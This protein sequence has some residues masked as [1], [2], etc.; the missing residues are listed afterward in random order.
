MQQ[1]LVFR[2]RPYSFRKI[3]IS[4]S[5]QEYSCVTIEQSRTD[6]VRV[7]FPRDTK[8]KVNE[9][10][11]VRVN[12]KSDLCDCLAASNPDIIDMSGGNVDFEGTK[13]FI[14]FLLSTKRVSFRNVSAFFC[15]KNI[16]KFLTLSKELVSLRVINCP[17]ISKVFSCLYKNSLTTLYLTDLAFPSVNEQNKLF[18][19]LSVCQSLENLT[20]KGGLKQ[21]YLCGNSSSVQDLNIVNYGY[22]LD[23][24]PKITLQNLRKVNLNFL[25]R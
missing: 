5:F 22:N 21:N 1:P 10:C 16:N 3:A 9:L 25:L 12:L 20:L 2:G 14:N 13:S 23:I 15:Y 19:G 7:N 17:L 4:R 6:T 18:K 8:L 24:F 11:L